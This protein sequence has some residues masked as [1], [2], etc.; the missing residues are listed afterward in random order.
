MSFF[1]LPLRSSLPR[2]PSRLPRLPA[3]CPGRRW[4]AAGARR[5]GAQREHPGGRGPGGARGRERQLATRACPGAG[6]SPPSPT[7][8]LSHPHCARRPVPRKPHPPTA[9][10]RLGVG[11]YGTQAACRNQT[12]KEEGWW[13]RMER[14]ERRRRQSWAR[15]PGGRRASQAPPRS[16]ADRRG[17]LGSTDSQGRPGARN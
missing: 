14:R 3:S 15:G 7:L 17:L 6:V 9:L 13:M 4:K 1:L 10:R 5:A 2:R 11:G 12:A 16:P 8:R